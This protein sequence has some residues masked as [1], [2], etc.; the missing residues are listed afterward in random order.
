M[1]TPSRN[2]KLHAWAVDQEKRGDLAAAANGFL[3]A[4]AHEDA[5]R[6][7]AGLG[8]FAEAG[9][10]LLS[11]IRYQRNRTSNLSAADRKIALKAAIWFARGGDVRQAVELY[12]VLDERSRAIELLRSVGDHV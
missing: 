9:Q 11:A 8:R 4:G 2:P 3:R 5:A 1:T 7:F 12:L 10:A 6:A